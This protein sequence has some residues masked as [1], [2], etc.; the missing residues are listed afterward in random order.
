M[1]VM[2]V[3]C[4]CLV[5][6]GLAQRS[7]NHVVDFASDDAEVG[8][9]RLLRLVYYLLQS[10]GVEPQLFLAEIIF[11]Y[12]DATDVLEFLLVLGQRDDVLGRERIF[13]VPAGDGCELHQL[14]EYDASFRR[15]L[16]A[17]LTS[18]LVV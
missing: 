18:A 9:V 2:S 4:F 16:D 1:P 17:G 11:N 10:V 13:H 14:E 3:G 15:G 6:S 5:L 7:P 8:L 12:F